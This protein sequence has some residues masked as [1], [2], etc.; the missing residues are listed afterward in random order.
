MREP[1]KFPHGW[2]LLPGAVLGAAM[3]IALFAWVFW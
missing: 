3:W 1:E 2:W